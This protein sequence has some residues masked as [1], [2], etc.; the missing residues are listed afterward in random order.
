MLYIERCTSIYFTRKFVDVTRL[1]TLYWKAMVDL[2][3]GV[4]FAYD[5]FLHGETR[6]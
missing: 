1:N 6:K 5:D 2:Q 3:E 4:K